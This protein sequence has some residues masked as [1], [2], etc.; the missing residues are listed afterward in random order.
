MFKIL[1]KSKEFPQNAKE[2]ENLIYCLLHPIYSKWCQTISA[3]LMFF[4]EELYEIRSFPKDG[5]VL[6]HTG[7][8]KD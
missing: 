5:E 4:T 6:K 7:A 8:Y 3:E 1:R 2:F